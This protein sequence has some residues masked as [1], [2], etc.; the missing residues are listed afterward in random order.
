[1]IEFEDIED[2]HLGRLTRE[3]AQQR[4]SVCEVIY[5]AAN[6]TIIYGEVEGTCRITGKHNKKGVFFSKWVR[7]TF[8]DH[9]FLFAGTI[10]SNEALFCFEEAST[11]IQGMRGK[12]KPQRFRTYSHFVHD[13]KWY[14]FGKRKATIDISRGHYKAV[15]RK[16]YYRSALYIDWYALGDKDIIIDLLRFV[17]NLGKKTAQGWGAVLRWEVIDWHEDWSIRGPKNQRG[18]Q[19]LMRALPM[20]RSSVVCG[21]RP[22][23][24]L[25]RHQFPCVIPH[26]SGD[27]TV[28]T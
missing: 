14:C 10:I 6:C 24:W 5:H 28:I 23:Y 12:D 4:P 26:P 1:M 21:L 18:Q 20:E 9:A 15:H 2:Q 13:G 27:G 16:L 7:D 3:A 11:L 8:T 25:P 17:T 19:K 22:S